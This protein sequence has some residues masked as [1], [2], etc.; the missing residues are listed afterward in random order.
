[1]HVHSHGRYINKCHRW[2]NNF[3]STKTLRRIDRKKRLPGSLK[4]HQFI[5]VKRGEAKRRTMGLARRGEN[6][7]HKGASKVII[8][9]LVLVFRTK[10]RNT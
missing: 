10:S 4:D 6:L 1:M 5:N 9:K 7:V 3:R 2:R 8:E